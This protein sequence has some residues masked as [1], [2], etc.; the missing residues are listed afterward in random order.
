MRPRSS[1]VLICTLRAASYYAAAIFIF[2][3]CAADEKK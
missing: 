2:P 1:G 3:L